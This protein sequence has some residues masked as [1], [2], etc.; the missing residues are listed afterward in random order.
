MDRETEK[1]TDSPS[2]IISHGVKKCNHFHSR[3]TRIVVDADEFSAVGA[4]VKGVLE[5][6]HAEDGG[7]ETGQTERGAAAE[8]VGE[9]TAAVVHG[10]HDGVI[11]EGTD[12]ADGCVGFGGRRLGSELRDL[13]VIFEIEELV[14]VW[15]SPI[16]H[17]LPW[18]VSVS[19]QRSHSEHCESPG[20]V[21]GGGSVDP[22]HPLN[23]IKNA[24]LVLSVST[25]CSL[26]N[27]FLLLTSSPA[28]AICFQRYDARTDT[29]RKRQRGESR[30]TT[31]C[32]SASGQST[33]R[34]SMTEKTGNFDADLRGPSRLPSHSHCLTLT[35]PPTP[36]IHAC[37]S[38]LPTYSSR[39]RSDAS[40][41]RPKLKERP[42][43]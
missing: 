2:H 36:S 9:R 5:S 39:F 16:R 42:G 41:S 38:L 6:I 40:T 27:R 37:C 19:P 33:P 18:L 14:S 1:Q 4:E 34:R 7:A 17:P 20:L 35:H 22:T 30:K 23:Q 24:L 11:A 13:I 15:V 8:G 43:D 12:D 32:P 25:A 29:I 21:R 26:S 3:S 28:Q 31:P 10:G